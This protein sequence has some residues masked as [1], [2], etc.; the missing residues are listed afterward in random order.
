MVAPNFPRPKQVSRRSTMIW[1]NG[2]LGFMDG[3]VGIFFFHCGDIDVVMI[4]ILFESPDV[5]GIIF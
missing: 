1:V 3:R 5:V 4:T 2:F